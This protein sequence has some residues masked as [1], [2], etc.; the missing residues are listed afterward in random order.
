MGVHNQERL[1]GEGWIGCLLSLDIKF[2]RSNIADAMASTSLLQ[3]TDS[4]T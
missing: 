4:V 1:L 3:Y 2:L